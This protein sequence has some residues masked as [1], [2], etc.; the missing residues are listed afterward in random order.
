MAC[1]NLPERGRI[2]IF[3]R[4][5]YEEVLI[6]R[7][8]PEIKQAQR[9]PDDVLDQKTLWRERYRSIIDMENHLHRN[10]TRII[11]FFL[12]L[13]KE[14]QRKRFIARIDNPDKNSKLSLAD[15]E[16]RKH[17]KQYMHAYE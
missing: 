17:W 8:H 16:E 1:P 5:Y 13:S 12:H 3:N 2:G 10:G 15:I 4:S 9:L 11:K 14:E 7:V 6:V